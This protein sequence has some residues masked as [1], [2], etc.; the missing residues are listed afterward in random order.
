MR[1]LLDWPRASK[2]KEAG[3]SVEWFVGDKCGTIGDAVGVGRQ[4]NFFV[5]GVS[6]DQWDH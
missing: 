3:I 1:S 5:G 2:A 4:F 6:C